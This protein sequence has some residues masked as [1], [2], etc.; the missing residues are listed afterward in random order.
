MIHELCLILLVYQMNYNQCTLTQAANSLSLPSFR[1]TVEDASK[2]DEM[3]RFPSVLSSALRRVEECII[4]LISRGEGKAE[5]LISI[6][7]SNMPN[8][9]AFLDTPPVCYGMKVICRTF[10][11][12][13]FQFLDIYRI[14]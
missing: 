4:R 11:R 2:M 5:P 3:K 10:K 1:T 14:V 13:L 12:A 8:I 7:L 6:I 9:G